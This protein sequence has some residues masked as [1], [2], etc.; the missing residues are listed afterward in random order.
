VVK[1]RSTGRPHT[2][3]VVIARLSD[4]FDTVNGGIHPGLRLVHA[5]S[6]LLTDLF[7]PIRRRPA[8]ARAAAEA[9]QA[10]IDRAVI[11]KA[12]LVG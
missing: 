7:T 2:L 6:I 5:K 11:R 4:T 9:V 3:A 8:A 10:L 1:G 12:V